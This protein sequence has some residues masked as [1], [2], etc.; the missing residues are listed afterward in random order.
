MKLN[1]SNTEA[2]IGTVTGLFYA[3]GIFGCLLNSWLAD[4]VGRKWTTII[5]YIILLI[6]S[7]CQCGSVHVAMFIVFRFFVGAR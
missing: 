5:A 2:I 4:R 3:G 1:D 7:A 6:A